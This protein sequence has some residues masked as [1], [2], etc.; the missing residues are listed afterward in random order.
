MSL[1]AYGN[2]KQ[3]IRTNANTV[4]QTFTYNTETGYLPVDTATF[5]K[6]ERGSFIYPSSITG[7]YNSKSR[8][9]PGQG[10]GVAGWSRL[11]QQ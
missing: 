7:V 10:S 6:D 9:R 3:D 4:A 8:R 11:Y 2:W 1:G 5:T